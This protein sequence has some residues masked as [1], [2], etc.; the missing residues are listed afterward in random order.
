LNDLTIIR[1]ARIYPSSKQGEVYNCLVISNGRIIALGDDSIAQQFSTEAGESYDLGERAVFPGFTDAHIHLEEYAY[2]LVQVDCETADLQECLRRVKHAAQNAPPGKWIRGHGWD[3]NT[4]G[5]FGNLSELDAAAPQNPVYLTAKSLH[6]A[7]VNSLALKESQVIDQPA[8]PTFA[9]GDDSLEGILFENAMQLV[10]KK[11]PLPSLGERIA[12]IDKAQKRLLRYGITSIHDFDG[13]RCFEALQELQR[14]D[15]LHLRVTKNIQNDQF[16][17]AVQAGIRTGFGNEWLRIGHLKLFADGALGPQTAAMISPYEGQPDNKGL[18]L[19]DLEEITEIGRESLKAGLP[20]AI[21]AIGDLACRTV[22]KALLDLGG[23]TTNPYPPHRIEHLQIVHPAD[24]EYLSD[25]DV[26]ISM[27]P[28]HAPSDHPT[29]ERYWGDRNRWAYAW[30]SVIETGSLLIFGS[31]A[32]VESPDPF[33]GLY[34]A[35]SRKLAKEDPS[36]QLWVPEECLDLQSALEAYTVNPP[37]AVG[38]GDRLG[39]LKEGYLADLIVLE[40]D[41]Y[42]IPK[43]ELPGMRVQGV[44]TGGEWRFLEI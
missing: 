11:I 27:Q 37:I 24:L 7:W 26:T 23:S 22:I 39:R 20:L 10:S 34:A 28:L 25:C 5:R 2:S 6:A 17:P 12:A 29:A 4:W 33:L 38:T 30:K 35:V 40:Q 8:R 3:Q 31:D 13:R 14:E 36:S 19:L 42:T 32:P 9:K 41:P 16:L 15:R 44:M 43:A 1:N 21:H 18:L